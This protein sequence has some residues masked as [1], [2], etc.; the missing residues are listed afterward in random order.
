[1]LPSDGIT[2]NQS[3]SKFAPA[4]AHLFIMGA[5]AAYKPS[6]DRPMIV[7]AGVRRRCQ[8]ATRSVEMTSLWRDVS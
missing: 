3:K 6:S 2:D 1:M 4:S 7:G 8:I 5:I